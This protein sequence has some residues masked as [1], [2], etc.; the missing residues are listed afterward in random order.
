MAMLHGVRV[1]LHVENSNNAAQGTIMKPVLSRSIPAKAAI[2]AVALFHSSSPVAVAQPAI[3]TP[4]WHSSYI[5]HSSTE[6][7]NDKS[8]KLN[9]IQKHNAGRVVYHASHFKS[10]AQG[11]SA[12][13]DNLQLL[14]TRPIA[15]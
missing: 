5:H 1:S 8:S 12:L 11:T 6:L 2:V 13:R 10:V 9:Q 7:V 14:A 3:A 4:I 15:F